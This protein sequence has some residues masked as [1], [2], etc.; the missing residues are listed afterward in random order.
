MDILLVLSVGHQHKWRDILGSVGKC[1]KWGSFLIFLFNLPVIILYC[2]MICLLSVGLLL[3]SGISNSMH[4][5]K[6]TKPNLFLGDNCGTM[7]AHYIFFLTNVVFCIFFCGSVIFVKCNRIS[8]END[9]NMCD[10]MSIGSGPN[11]NSGILGLF[12]L[13]SWIGTKY[14]YHFS[15]ELLIYVSTSFSTAMLA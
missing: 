12:I 11:V 5:D 15:L 7:L 9:I 8:I 10:D 3:S 13:L 4:R 6:S 2:T 14:Q 1:T